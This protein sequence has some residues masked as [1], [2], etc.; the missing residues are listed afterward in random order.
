MLNPFFLNGSKSEQYLLQDLVNESIRMHGIEIYYMPR[1][2]IG[3][4]SIIREVVVSKFEDAV[5]L[6]A[7]VMSYDGWEGQGDTL[8]KF[9]IETKDELVLAISQERYET[10][11]QPLLVG[12]EN[13]K[14]ISRPKEGDLIYFPLGD[15]LFEIKHV[16]R[17]N[18]FYQLQKNYI[19]ELK[20]ELLRYEDEIIETQIKEIDDEV[21]ND[22]Y[23]VS[24]SLI[25][26]GTTAT[27]VAGI[28]TNTGSVRFISL[29]DR[30]SD[31]RTT[32]TVTLSPPQVSGGTTATAVAITSSTN[33][34]DSY[35]YIDRI[36][37]L[38]P[39]SGYTSAPSISIVGPV[40]SGAIATVGI[41][42]FGSVGLVTI[43][44]AGGPYIDPPIVTIS[45]NPNSAT[46]GD[47]SAEAILDEN[48]SVIGIRFQDAGEG[49]PYPPTITFSA[50]E[51]AAILVDNGFELNDTITG[52]ISGATARVKSWDAVGGVLNIS[53]I[54]GEF[55]PG[56][57]ITG[58]NGSIFVIDSIPLF[59]TVNA[60][61]DNDTIEEEAD[62]ILDFTE[63]NPF[64]EV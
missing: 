54:S 37:I 33:Y 15:R 12:K 22:G 25:G 36:L 30:G 45:P 48:G 41:A 56:E 38:D 44:D 8:S 55:V 23:I 62:N 20:C 60:F 19:Y 29:L 34:T 63:R 59:D 49:Y 16:K 4:N 57:Q 21:E 2:F 61:A 43:T 1:S 40:G 64:G 24:M 3:E 11:V 10:Y 47:A 51:S 17:D 31:Y 18:P 39:G 35:Y 26:I 53:N 5:P 42:T 50:P 14:L 6:E 13:L 46:Y 52:S 9:G 28:T 58:N 27:A 7:Y 32:P